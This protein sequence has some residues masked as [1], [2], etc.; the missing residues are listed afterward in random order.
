[1]LFRSDTE[2]KGHVDAAKAGRAGPARKPRRNDNMKGD[3]AIISSATKMK[4]AFAAVYEAYDEDIESKVSD[5]H[6]LNAAHH[7][8]SDDHHAVA[9]EPDHRG[10]KM[11]KSSLG[12]H[13]THTH[14]I[15]LHPDNKETHVKLPSGK[16]ASADHVAK[17]APKAPA[18]IHKAVANYHNMGE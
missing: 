6:G 17:Q 7:K 16:K 10:G 2:E 12:D 4:E 1:M 5:K 11:G 14:H 3:K 13:D 18:S 9:V 8:S 15:I